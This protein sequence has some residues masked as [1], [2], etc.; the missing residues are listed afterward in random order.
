MPNRIR[1]NDENF[2]KPNRCV[3]N[4]ANKPDIA[5]SEGLVLVLS[6]VRPKQ[7][8]IQKCSCPEKLIPVHTPSTLQF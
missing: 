8:D 6:T 5:N 4:C 1:V 7:A 2:G 3:G